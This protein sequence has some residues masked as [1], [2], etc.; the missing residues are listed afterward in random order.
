MAREMKTPK[1]GNNIF[2]TELITASVQLRLKKN[3]TYE[4]EGVM[5]VVS[6]KGKDRDLNKVCSSESV[7]AGSSE[8]VKQWKCEQSRRNERGKEGKRRREARRGDEGFYGPQKVDLQQTEKE[9]FH[10]VM[11]SFQE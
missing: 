9:V 6:H 11:M 5:G 4:G 3:Y 10:G 1:N 2:T 7:L 8:S